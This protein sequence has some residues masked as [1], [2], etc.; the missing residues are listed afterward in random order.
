[1]SVDNLHHLLTNPESKWLKP[2]NLLKLRPASPDASS[3]S[4]SSPFVKPRLAVVYDSDSG[5]DRLYGGFYSDWCGGGQWTHMM[6]FLATLLSAMHK[7]NVQMAVFVNGA[8]E[9]ERSVNVLKG[10]LS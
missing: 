6:D 9:P 5:L 7:E 8:M 2:V 1:M 4:S 10:K 3:S